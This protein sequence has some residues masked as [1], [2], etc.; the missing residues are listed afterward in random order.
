MKRA[1]PA[2]ALALLMLFSALAA[3]QQGMTFRQAADLDEL[4]ALIEE[5]AGKIEGDVGVY[6]LHV[7]SGESIALNADKQFQLA[8]VFKIPLLV[9][10]FKLIDEGH[11]S[12]DDRIVLSEK[13]KTF[14]S[15]LLAAMKSGLNPSINDL[16]LLMMAVSDNTATDILFELVGAERIA[17]YMAELGLTDTVIDLDTH[18]LILGYLGLD[19]DKRLT[20]QQLNRTPLEYWMS[21]ERQERL[22]RFDSEVHD[23]STPREIGT[24]LA[25]LVE[26]KI[27]DR[28]TSDTIIATLRHHTGARLITRFLPFGVSVA[29][30]GG[31]LSRDW[32]ETVLNDSGI[33][34]LPNG[35]HLVVCVFGN[36]LRSPWYEFEEAA[37]YISRYA[38][39]YFTGKPAE[40][41]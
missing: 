33:V 10:L 31:S 18:R 40:S 30:K 20:R 1:I 11:Y 39:D 36:D 3:A 27:V 28:E 6:A 25:K 37:G 13:M 26:G 34:F 41:K 17:A 38:Y 15:G 9:T 2:V 24:L 14:G 32:R 16:Q 29:R 23:A 5:E 8:S 19:M 4:Q 7:E 35:E 22:A 21:K 12:L